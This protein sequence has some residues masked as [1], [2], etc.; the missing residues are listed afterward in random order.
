M[1]ES[2]RNHPN[3]PAC[4]PFNINGS[5][6]K[7]KRMTAWNPNSPNYF[8]NKGS[9]KTKAAFTQEDAVA[10]VVAEVQP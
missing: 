8:L 10:E 4:Q 2:F 5:K 1:S 3:N 9:K 7:S 6:C